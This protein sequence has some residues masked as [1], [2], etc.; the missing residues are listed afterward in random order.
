MKSPI[1]PESPDVYEDRIINRVLE[2]M[3]HQLKFS[4]CNMTSIP[5][6]A[7]VNFFEQGTRTRQRNSRTLFVIQTVTP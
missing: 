1:G 2:K 7:E 4:E 6:E 3:N 5:N